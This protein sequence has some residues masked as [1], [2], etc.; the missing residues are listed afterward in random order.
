MLRAVGASRWQTFVKVGVPRTMPLFFASL[1]VAVSSAFVGSVIAEIV[2]SN[3]GVGYLLAV[4]ASDFDTPLA[5][6][7]LFVWP[8]WACCATGSS[9]SWSGA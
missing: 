4:A 9:R 1:Q 7:G 6:G 5:F 2:A 3:A 8:R